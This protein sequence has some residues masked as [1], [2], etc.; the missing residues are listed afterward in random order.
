MSS[1]FSIPDFSRS[2]LG[3][4]NLD[5]Y[6]FVSQAALVVIKVIVPFFFP[7]GHKPDKLYEHT[8]CHLS[9]QGS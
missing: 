9:H 5:E 7:D 1:E 4:M 6:N 3:G 2:S 8:Y